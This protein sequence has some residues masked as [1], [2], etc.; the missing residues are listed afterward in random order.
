[1][2]SPGPAHAQW[3]KSTYSNAS[4]NCIEVA[5]VARKGVTAVAVRDSKDPHARELWFH[6]RQWKFFLARVKEGKL[7]LA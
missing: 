3:R 5:A 1:M 2:T 4:G 6:A 7:D